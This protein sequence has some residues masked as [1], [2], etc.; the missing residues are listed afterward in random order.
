MQFAHYWIIALSADYGAVAVRTRFI[1]YQKY[2]VAGC[3]DSS[4]VKRT[5][6]IVNLGLS[7]FTECSARS[8]RYVHCKP[9]YD[10]SC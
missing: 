3:A 2:L 6:L 1:L 5:E 10:V 4:S 9:D 7:A 8:I